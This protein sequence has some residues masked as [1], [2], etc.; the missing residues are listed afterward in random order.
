MMKTILFLV[1]S[2]SNAFAVEIRAIDTSEKLTVKCSE[3][4][5]ISYGQLK[6]EIL[7]WEN[8]TLHTQYLIENRLLKRGADHL[9][10]QLENQHN[11]ISN[12]LAQF[13][14]QT[15]CYQYRRE[16][17]ELTA[18]FSQIKES[19]K[20]EKP[21]DQVRLCEIQLKNTS[22]IFARGIA[23]IEENL[24][25]KAYLYFGETSFEVDRILKT[26]ADCQD[27][28]KEKLREI[29][30]HSLNTLNSIKFKS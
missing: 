5:Q 24:K 12:A 29:R 19:L 11:S 17:A 25:Q 1:I 28:E 7:K 26:S 30:E 15:N 18:R 8:Q 6:K 27:H 20:L 10:S 23:S 22:A 3:A 2:L 13:G 9:I 4:Q 16:V 21:K 14:R